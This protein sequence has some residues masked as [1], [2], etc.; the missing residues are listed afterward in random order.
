MAVVSGTDSA[1]TIPP[2]A[3]RAISMA[4]LALVSTSPRGRFAT[5]N[6]SRAAP[7]TTN[8][9][10]TNSPTTTLAVQR[11]QRNWNVVGV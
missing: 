10:A 7:T 3:D 4:T 6:S 2:T 5:L 11:P 9:M 1:S 8:P